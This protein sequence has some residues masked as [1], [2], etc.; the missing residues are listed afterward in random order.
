MVVG[1]ALEF[2]LNLSFGVLNC[3]AVLLVLLINL[4]LAV[5]YFMVASLGERVVQTTLP[6]GALVPDAFSHLFR[7]QGGGVQTHGLLL[8]H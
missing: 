7:V 6:G 4:I 3:V 1:L 2:S 8:H 5:V